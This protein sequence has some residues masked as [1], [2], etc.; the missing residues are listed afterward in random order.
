MT[1]Y[2]VGALATTSSTLF[3]D[4]VQVFHFNPVPKSLC[5]PLSQ[6]KEVCGFSFSPRRQ[7]Y[8]LGSVVSSYGA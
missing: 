5:L 7:Q 1:G 6:A 8:S 4:R 3:K 2:F